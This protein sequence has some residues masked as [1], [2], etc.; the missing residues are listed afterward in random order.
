MS[1][2]SS[3]RILFV[4]VIC[5]VLLFLAF[6][7]SKPALVAE[8]LSGV[9]ADSR[10]VYLLLAI[11]VDLVIL[12]GR[13]VK[14][15]AILLPLKRVPPLS[16]FSAIVVGITSNNFLF[17]RFDELVRAYV[18]GRRENVSR[19]AVLGTIA[20]ERAWD[21]FVVT[22]AFS[23][24]GFSVALSSDFFLPGI[25]AG[26][27]FLLGLLLLFLIARYREG[28][29]S[30]WGGVGELF[31]RRQL[32][33]RSAEGFVRGINAFPRDRRLLWLMI[34]S[35]VEWGGELLFIACLSMAVGIQLSISEMLLFISA[36][37]LSF[38]IPSSPASI[39]PYHFL[40][41][42]ALG[43]LSARIEL[44]NAFVILTHAMM[45]IPVSLLGI[46]FLWREGLGFTEIRLKLRDD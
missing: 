17:F 40:G 30:L 11:A 13:L 1:T 12:C 45:V 31:S 9:L 41:T 7:R 4:S 20:G 27:V 8:H 3:L 16:L 37:F 35:G 36:S 5:G 39:G 42:I 15:R 23:L 34:G 38:A 29:I 6:W 32:F 24:T 43:G 18:L 46:V 22:V 2:R 14:W 21:L 44:R 25:I 19:G 33:E 28:F 26:S 10:W